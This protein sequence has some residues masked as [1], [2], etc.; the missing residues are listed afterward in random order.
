M[1]ADP[2]QATAV[3]KLILLQF[4]KNVN[5]SYPHKGKAANKVISPQV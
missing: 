1:S 4:I 2:C 5:F 3:Q